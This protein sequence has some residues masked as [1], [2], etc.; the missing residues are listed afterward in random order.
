MKIIHRAWVFAFALFFSSSALAQVDSW[1]REYTGAKGGRLVLYQPQLES[2]DNYATLVARQAAA[3]AP[4]GSKAPTLGT[5]KLTGKTEVDQQTRKVRIKDIQISEV[6]FP[7]LDPKLLPQLVQ[8][9]KDIIPKDDLVLALD[10]ILTN[11]ERSQGQFQTVAVKNDPPAIYFSA[12]PA[13][14]GILDGQPIWSPVTG[15]NLKYAVNTNWDLFQE[16]G[17]GTLYLRN[18]G[19]WLK[20]KNLYGPWEPAGTLPAGFSQIPKAQENWKD[21]VASLPGTPIPADKVPTVFVSPVPAEMILTSGAPQYQ[22]IPGTQLA[23]VPNTESNFFFD[24]G[25]RNYYFLVSGRWFRHSGLPG[26]KWSYASD[27]LPQDFKQIPDDHP[28]AA[29]LAEVP[30]TPEAE[31]AVIASNIPQKAKVKR[32]ATA[33]VEYSGEPQ[34]QPIEKTELKYATNTP[35]QV[36]EFKGKYYLVKD[37]VWFIAQDPKG[38]WTVTDQVPKEIYDIP[39]SSS[40]YNVTYVKVYES[41]DDEVEFGYTA[42]YMGAFVVGT[43]LGAALSY[44]NGWYYPPYYYGGAYY[45]RPYTY[46]AAAYYNPWTGNYYRGARYYGPY[47][48]AGY[49]AAYNPYTGTYARGA[50]AYGPYGGRA[51]AQAYNPWTNTYAA[52]RQGGNLYSSWGSSY[53]Q[54]GDDWARTA[55]YSQGD[56][57]FRGYQTSEGKSGAIARGNQGFVAKGDDLY[58]GRDGNVYRRTDDGWQKREDGGWNDVEGG[59]QAR[60]SELKSSSARSSSAASS[61]KFQGYQGQEG[62]RE[63]L[64]TSSRQGSASKLNETARDRGTAPKRTAKVDTSVQN[65]LSRNSVSR[66]RGNQRVSQYDNYQRSGGSR[67]LASGSRSSSFGDSGGGR[68]LGAGGGG[69][70]R[71]G[72]GGGGGRRR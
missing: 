36:I 69:G 33:K 39:P 54:R 26:G 9:V 70:R 44:G 57:T 46:G 50:A 16:E 66:D 49:G 27:N 45:P 56:A 38:P 24:Y 19:S 35:N 55:R 59:R 14:L 29:V 52:T 63:L 37:G 18:E 43:A 72:G 10:R 6:N 1:P 40:M 20:A 68:S 53:V 58:A 3:V 23:W 34:F 7:T 28:K 67:N 13:I 62:K 41:D 64:P 5:F 22:L 51:A 21:V 60:N 15:T 2:W 4:P 11:L 25:D 42:G 31:E 12:A 32:D 17:T 61:Q 8:A 48:G 30:G 65:N 71:G 47:G